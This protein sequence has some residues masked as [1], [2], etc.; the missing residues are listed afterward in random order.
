[1]DP[2]TKGIPPKEKVANTFASELMIPTYLAKKS[3]QGSPL[4]LDTISMIKS[5][6][7]S[8][9]MVALRK[10]ISLNHHMGFFACYDSSGKRKYFSK[11]DDLHYYFSPPPEAPLG[12]C[13]SDLILKKTTDQSAKIIDG[14]IW[15]RTEDANDVIV[16]EHAFHYHGGDFITIVWWEEEEPIWRLNEL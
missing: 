5:T 2:Y 7:D 3:L 1:M 15:C 6:Y 12:S 8:S 13:V 4:N 10:T 16:H 14:S 9:F 11:N